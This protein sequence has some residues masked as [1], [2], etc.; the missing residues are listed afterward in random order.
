MNLPCVLVVEE[1]PARLEDMRRQLAG[2]ASE[3]AFDYSSSIADARESLAVGDVSVLVMDIDG[4]DDA[5]DAFLRTVRR[6]FPD[7]AIVIQSGDTETARLHR[8]A[9]SDHLYLARNC[10]AEELTAAL[11]EAER[12]HLAF[13]ENPRALS[14]ADITAILSDF[15]RREIMHGRIGLDDIPERMRP[16]LSEDLLKQ[17][18]HFRQDEGAAPFWVEEEDEADWDGRE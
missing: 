6:E 5:H 13:Q 1:D 2:A 8:M 11:T 7:V 15:F 3:L 10:S 14:N 18:D 12:L 9:D 17:A 16:Y 4:V